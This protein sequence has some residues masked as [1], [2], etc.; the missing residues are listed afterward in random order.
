LLSPLEVQP[1][2]SYPMIVIVHGRPAAVVTPKFFWDERVAS[3]LRNGYFVFQP[4]PR[5]SFG[6]G[7]AFTRANV[8]DF[9][10]GDLR[11]DFAG[12]DAAKQGPRS[13]RGGWY[14]ADLN[15]RLVDWFDRY[16]K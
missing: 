11:D 14:V 1:G 3:W 10:G 13:M 16:L 2:K 9:G 15:R 8:R 12:I 6:Q 4:N 7:E 5:G